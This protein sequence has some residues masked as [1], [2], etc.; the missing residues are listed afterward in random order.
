LHCLAEAHVV[1]EHSPKIVAAKKREPRNPFNLVRTQHKASRLRCCGDN[2]VARHVLI[3]HVES[4]RL[5][6]P[7]PAV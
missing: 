5:L 3:V 1:G 6:F 7:L 4:T 2:E